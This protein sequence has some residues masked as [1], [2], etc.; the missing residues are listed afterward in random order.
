[1]L[2][3]RII[4]TL[5][6]RGRQLIKGQQFNGWRSCGLALQ[7]ARIHA[8]RGVDEL[9]LL[10]IGASPEGR[11]PDLALVE[12]LSA[13]MFTPLAVGGGVNDLKEIDLLLRAGA[14]K[15]VLGT[16]APPLAMRAARHFGSQAIVA[17][18]DVTGGT[19]AWQCG[20]AVSHLDPVYYAKKLADEGVGEIMLTSID[21]EG[22]MQG[23]DLDLIRAVS[24]AVNIPVIAHGGCGTYQHMVEAIEAGADAVAAGAMFQ[25]T[26]ATP[27]GAAKYLRDHGIRVRIVDEEA[28]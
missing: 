3:H 15:I 1:M 26:D 8:M 6:C 25:F 10:D 27:A 7:A 2:A 4:P 20:K 23:Y 16:N 22:M 11:G 21:R 9:V 24:Q 17:A 14:D 5:L 19:V 12:E 28:A 18:I 13:A